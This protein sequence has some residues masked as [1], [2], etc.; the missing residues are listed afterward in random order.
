MTKAELIE[1]LKPFHDGAEILVTV[2]GDVFPLRGVRMEWTSHDGKMMV[3]DPW[4]AL[5]EVKS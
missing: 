3:D 1:Q 2:E 5:I 4:S